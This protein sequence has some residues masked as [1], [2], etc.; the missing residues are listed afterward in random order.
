[1]WL[2]LQDNVVE[3]A[4]FHYTGLTLDI[5]IKEKVENDRGIDPVDDIILAEEWSLQFT[6]KGNKLSR[7]YLSERP[8]LDLYHIITM[9]SRKL[10]EKNVGIGESAGNQHFLL[11]P[12]CF[13]LLPKQ[14]S[15]FQSHLLYRLQ[16]LSIWTGL[17][18]CR[19]VMS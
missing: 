10:F 14:I 2:I 12:R 13:L 16:T 9:L 15:I 18:F 7:L 19:L 8:D 11:F 6:Y 17:K 5:K 4:V 1:M 3:I